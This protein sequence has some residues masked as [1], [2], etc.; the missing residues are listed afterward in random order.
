V[1]SNVASV[2]LGAYHSA[3][4]TEDGDLYT[5]G[6]NQF[7]QLGDGTDTERH[8]P[9]KVLSN[10]ASVSLGDFH[11]AYSICI[12]VIVF[13]I[14]YFFLR[15]GPH[16]ICLLQKIHLINFIISWINALYPFLSF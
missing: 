6:D 8:A 2:S 9:V 4:V 16:H 15:E 5:W 12:T 14:V 1:L 3:A 13:L 10:V 11:S 7:G